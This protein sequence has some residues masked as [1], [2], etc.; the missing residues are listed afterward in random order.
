MVRAVEER[1][2]TQA[3]HAIA[4]PIRLTV[5]VALERHPRLSSAELAT[6]VDLPERQLMRHLH[7]LEAAG[8]ITTTSDGRHS[9]VSTGWAAFAAR[10]EAMQESADD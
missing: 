10:L 6:A 2:S 4:H 9:A 5:L 7:L 3:L 8:L 1:L